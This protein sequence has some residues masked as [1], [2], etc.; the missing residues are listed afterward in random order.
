MHFKGL[1]DLCLLAH[2]IVISLHYT[3]HKAAACLGR[4]SYICV[5]MCFSTGVF[6][7]SLWVWYVCI[8]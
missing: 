4:I 5:C 1:K 3:L 7:V 2:V 6:L 8:K